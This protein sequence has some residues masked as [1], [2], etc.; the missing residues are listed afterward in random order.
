M[1]YYHHRV[2]DNLIYREERFGLKTFEKFK[3]HPDGLIYQS[4]TY[5]P[6]VV[7]DA[8][9]GH[10]SIEDKQYGRVYYVK[11]FVKNAL[12]YINRHI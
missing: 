6:D 4:V 12:W 5:D 3:K 8:Q 2:S 1:W 7:F 9:Q 10:L 11:I